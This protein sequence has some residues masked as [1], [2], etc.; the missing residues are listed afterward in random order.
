M[1]AVNGT[2]VVRAVLQHVW[3]HH[4][5]VAAQVARRLVAAFYSGAEA[6]ELLP[7]PRSAV[8]RSGILCTAAP[9]E[10][11]ASTTKGA[12][13]ITLYTVASSLLSFQPRCGSSRLELESVCYAAIAV[14]RVEDEVHRTPADP[15]LRDIADELV[16]RM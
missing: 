16:R 15:L 5:M 6:L 9:H 12:H 4:I 2:G 1:A 10:R 3:Q 14:A 11:A 7:D 8:A 13:H